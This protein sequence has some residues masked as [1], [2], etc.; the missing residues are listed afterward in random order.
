MSVENVRT[1]YATLAIHASASTKQGIVHTTHT[2]PAS[3]LGA[4]VGVCVGPRVGSRVGNDLFL[5]TN[6]GVM[7]NVSF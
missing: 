5:V 1:L 7:V 3:E 4:C 6:V 2:V